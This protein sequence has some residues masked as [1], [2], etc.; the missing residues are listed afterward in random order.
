VFTHLAGKE[1]QAATVLRPSGKVWIEGE[2]YDGIS[3][4]GFIEKGEK[5]KVVRTE[6]AQVYVESVRS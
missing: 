6:S 1:G 3:E 5:V 4:S 2:L